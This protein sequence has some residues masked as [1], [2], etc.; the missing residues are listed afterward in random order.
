MNRRNPYEVL[1][2]GPDASSEEVKSAFHREALRWHPDTNPDDPSAET[3][4]KAAAEAYEMLCATRNRRL[5]PDVRSGGATGFSGFD[6]GRGCG[7]GRGRG[8][9][10]RFHR[11]SWAGGWTGVSRSHLPEITLS[12]GEALAG[13]EGRIALDSV[14]GGTMLVLR[15]PPDLKDGDVVLVDGLTR[16][17][18]SGFAG[19]IRLRI[20]IDPKI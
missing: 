10:R 20:N 4:F 15:L 12:P 9:G 13:C 17:G 8:C 6:S 19:E 14:L 2:I 18:A 1:G 5:P 16:E 7:R 3:R 11:G